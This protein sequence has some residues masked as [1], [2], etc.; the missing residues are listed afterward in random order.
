MHIA[1]E[2]PTKKRDMPIVELAMLPSIGHN[3]VRAGVDNF[4]V[5]FGVPKTELTRPF[6]D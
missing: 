4:E 2:I 6:K 5:D 3:D 1:V